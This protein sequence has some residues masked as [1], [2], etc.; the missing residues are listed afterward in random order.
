M[1]KEI[2]DK[3]NKLKD[4]L[5]SWDGRINILKIYILLKAIYT[6]NEIST[7]ITKTIFI[8]LEQIILKFVWNNQT[9]N[10]QSN[11]EKEEQS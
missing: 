5:R 8:E 10:S 1:T 3:T 2:E 6:L 9:P 7:K 11:L 4:I